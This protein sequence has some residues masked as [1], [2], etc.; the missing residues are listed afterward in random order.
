LP[1]TVIISSERSIPMN[2]FVRCF[3]TALMVIALMVGLSGCTKEGP[4][5]RAGKKIDK[6]IEKA[7]EQIEKKTPLKV[8]EKDTVVA[9]SSPRSRCSHA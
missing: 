8:G 2:K 4:A 9:T 3:T 5:E 7:G 6:A 1:G